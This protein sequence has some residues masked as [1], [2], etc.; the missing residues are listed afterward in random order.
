MRKTFC[1]FPSWKN[2][3]LTSDYAE[4][5]LIFGKRIKS[6]LFVKNQVV[7]KCILLLQF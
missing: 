3:F 5:K 7:Q 6:I 2:L 1:V 4:V